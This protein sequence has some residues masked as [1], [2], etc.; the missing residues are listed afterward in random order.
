MSAEE[1]IFRRSSVVDHHAR[2]VILLATHLHLPANRRIPDLSTNRRDTPAQAS[3]WGCLLFTN[4][5]CSLHS[6]NDSFQ[7]LTDP[8]L[9]VNCK[10]ISSRVALGLGTALHY[11]NKILGLEKGCSHEEW[12]GRRRSGGTIFV[13]RMISLPY[14][15]TPSCI[16]HFASA[17]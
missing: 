8:L 13:R 10:N 15:S 3:T 5:I 4:L 16:R 11:T 2:S 9:R 1:Q 14:T 12:L 7:P 6:L 17:T